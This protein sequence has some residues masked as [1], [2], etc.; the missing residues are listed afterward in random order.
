[1]LV[2]E[3]AQAC[4]PDLELASTQRRSSTRARAPSARSRR[5]AAARRRRARRGARVL[6]GGSGRERVAAPCASG[7]RTQRASA[8]RVR[9]EEGDEAR[10]GARRAARRSAEGGEARRARARRRGRRSAR[11]AR[12]R[13]TCALRRD[14]DGGVVCRAGRVARP[15]FQVG[16]VQARRPPSERESRRGEIALGWRLDAVGVRRA[17]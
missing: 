15:Q 14:A 17:G 16:S 9:L 12:H 4:G 8:K 10:R 3:C 1:M 2:C 13:C 5:L 7:A 6:G 11:T